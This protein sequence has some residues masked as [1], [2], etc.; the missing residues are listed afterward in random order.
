MMINRTLKIILIV[1]AI[2]L[3]GLSVPYMRG[4]L[5]KNMMDY[6]SAIFFLIGGI[7]VL[8]VSYKKG[9]RGEAG[10]QEPKLF[11]ILAIVMVVGGT[12]IL[13]LKVFVP[14]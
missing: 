10:R 12:I 2:A 4:T 5:G 13:I 1:I 7:S 9:R 6:F 3:G 11:R 8:M 14:H